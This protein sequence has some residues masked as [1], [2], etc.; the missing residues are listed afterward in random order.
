MSNKTVFD[1][2]NLVIKLNK[3]NIKIVFFDIDG[4]LTNSN[5]VMTK[6]TIKTLNRLIDKNIYI[7]LCS[8]RI[9][10]Y[11]KDYLK[12]I[13]KSKYTISNNGALIYDNELNKVIISHKLYNKDLEYL[14]DYSNKNNSSFI[15][16][17]ISNKYANKYV[18]DKENKIII[19][20]INEIKEDKLQLV[21]SNDDINVMKELEYYINS[22]TDLKVINKSFDYLNEVKNGYYFF[23]IV[24]N[25]V[26]KGTAIKY[27]L[28]ILN[29]NKENSICFGDS[30]N[31]IEMFN[32]VGTSVAMKNS[33]EEI[34]NI[35]DYITDTNDNDGISTF[36]NKY[37]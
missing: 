26:N 15:V 10:S 9:N 2:I 27:L 28:K 5:K 12:L 32:S 23:D 1:I 13:N 22:K 29:I 3:L 21:I 19:N 33:I 25:N 17:T 6:N 35:A 14:W 24:N 7:V 34:K 20:N 11:I 31:D 16:N 18:N 36:C 37:L 30:I 8:G 4:T